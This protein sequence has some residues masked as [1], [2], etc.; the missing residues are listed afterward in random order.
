VP[1]TRPVMIDDNGAPAIEQI[2]RQVVRQLDQDRRLAARQ[3]RQQLR[4]VIRQR[5]SPGEP[6][7][8]DPPGRM[9]VEQPADLD[10]LQVPP[11]KKETTGHDTTKETRHG[12]VRIGPD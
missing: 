1:G 9:A 12:C 4:P 3:R 2:G 6:L 8:L 7:I 5:C 10:H 11:A